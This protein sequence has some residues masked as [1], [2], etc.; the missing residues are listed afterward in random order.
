[1]N[2]KFGEGTG[3]IFMDDVACR[4][5]E[6]K[7]LDCRYDNITTD[8]THAEDAGLQCQTCECIGISSLILIL[9]R[10]MYLKS[11]RVHLAAGSKMM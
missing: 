5:S 4:G 1:M 8:D 3:P 2:A 11:I 9:R 7:L 6:S 10:I